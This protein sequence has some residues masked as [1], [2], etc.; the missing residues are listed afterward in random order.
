[1]SNKRKQL[2]FSTRRLSRLDYIFYSY[3]LV[4]IVENI[5]Y[6]FRNGDNNFQLGDLA[7]YI[8]Q[9]W[10]DVTLFCLNTVWV[11]IGYFMYEKIFFELIILYN[12]LLVV[13]KII[14]DFNTK[15]LFAIHSMCKIVTV[16][17]FLIHV[18]V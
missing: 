10:F 16:T 15:K 5:V 17:L 11:V 18:F 4:Y 8:S 2:F 12:V 14:L 1:M 9:H 13:M 7:K 3:A 6:M